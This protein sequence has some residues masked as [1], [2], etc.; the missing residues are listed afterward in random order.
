MSGS[1]TWHK[2]QPTEPN[3]RDFRVD[4]E[5]DRPLERGC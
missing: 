5:A 3:T 1:A 2:R 4:D